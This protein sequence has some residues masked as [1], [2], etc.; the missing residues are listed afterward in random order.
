VID[1][2]V[3]NNP[4]FSHFQTR[5]L[6]EKTAVV[7]TQLSLDLG[8]RTRTVQRKENYWLLPDGQH[9]ADEQVAVINEDEN[10]CFILENNR[11][12]K[13]EI[14]SEFTNRY[15]SLMPTPKAPTMLISGIPMHRIKGTTPDFDTLQKI[16]A[17]NTPYGKILDTATGLGY[18]AIKAAQTATAVVTIEFDPAV[19]GICKLNPWSRE[20]FTNPKINQLIGDS[21]DLAPVFPGNYF[22]AIIH[23]PPMF[24]LAGQLYSGELY[25]TF[26]RILK[27]N[28]R[29]FHYIG[30]PESKHG[31]GIGRGVIE[32]LRKAGFVVSPRPNAFG[33]FAQKQ[34]HS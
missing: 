15:Y 10:G 5:P 13:V 24:N 4:I 33:V 9:L 11:L 34:V 6:A 22:N 26:F 27:P 12:R 20:L 3:P 14:F 19:L 17:L 2:S 32:R 8:L 31:A 18:T 23:D 29:L 7:E 28:G 30:N 25:A 16:K 21:A 1:L